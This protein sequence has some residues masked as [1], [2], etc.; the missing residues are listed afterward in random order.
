MFSI[1]IFGN[2]AEEGQCNS[3]FDIIVAVNTRSDGIDDL[4]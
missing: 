4:R 3:S 2:A 1:D